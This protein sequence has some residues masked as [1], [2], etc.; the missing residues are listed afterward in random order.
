MAIHGDLAVSASVT[1]EF[2][3]AMAYVV[4]ASKKSAKN[5]LKM[6]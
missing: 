3:I 2:E 6:V 5:M 1:V 4:I